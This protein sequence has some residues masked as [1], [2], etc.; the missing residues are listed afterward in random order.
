MPFKIPGWGGLKSSPQTAGT[1]TPQPDAS[2]Q[3]LPPQNVPVTFTTSGTQKVA[4]LLPLTGRGNDVGEAMMNAAQLAMVDLGATNFELMSRDTS[5]TP[6]VARSAADQAIKDGASLILGPLFA[7]DTKAVSPMAS[8]SNVNV[9]SFSTDSSVVSNNTFI[10]GFLPQS[11]IARVIDFAMTRGQKQIALIAPRDSYG[12]IAARAFGSVMSSRGNATPVIVRYTGSKPTA[13]DTAILKSTGV[14][15]VIIATN[16]SVANSISGQL[17]EMG[18]TQDKVVRLGTGLWDQSD[19]AKLSNLQGAF[20]AASSP[21]SRTR[22]EKK[23]RETYGVTP[24][25]LASLGYDAV[26][27]AVVLQK[28]GRGFARDALLNPNGFAGVDG[29]FRFRADGLNERG[30]AVMTIQNGTAQIV[31]DA[32]KSFLK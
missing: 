8:Q 22:F 28:S 12:D 11:Q 14:N 6:E 5:G 32:P 7:E 19:V 13:Q 16:G 27:L 1:Q 31:Q 30:L 4:L 29:I 15:A 25:R 18:L 20:Y 10:L 3:P 24:P 23:Y 17:N 9:I 21:T 26:A 2:A